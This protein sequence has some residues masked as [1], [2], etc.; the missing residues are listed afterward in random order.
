MGS[1]ADAFEQYLVAEKGAAT[2]TV[3]S[4]VTDAISLL[5]YGAATGATDLSTLDIHILRA[6]LA[7][8]R[9][10]GAS[11]SSI[12]RKIAAARSFTALMYRRGVIKKDFGALLATPRTERV[13]PEV[14]RVDQAQTLMDS[15]AEDHTPAG[16]RDRA[17]LEILYATGIRVAELAGLDIGNIDMERQ[18]IRV[19][20]KGGRERST[21]YGIPAQQAIDEWLRNGRPYLAK[22]ESKQALF[23][24]VRGKRI[25]VRDV[26]RIVHRRMSA[27]EDAP[28]LAPHGLRHTAATHVLEGGADL[29]DVQELLGHATLATTQIYT[30]VS[31]ARLRA[32]YERAH[33]R[34]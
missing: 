17:I 11:R 23:L 25:D 7:T 8:T 2:H 1:A 5:D 9:N 10:N 6:W 30:H 24:G 29:R 27:I 34:A 32:V 20:G 21:P 13:L 18:L 4:Y 22:P 14:L 26:R 16:Y 15:L 12:A 31:V 33:P 19:F 28:N 3:R